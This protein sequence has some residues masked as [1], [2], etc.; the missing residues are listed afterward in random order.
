MTQTDRDVQRK[1]K[2]PRRLDDLSGL[3]VSLREDVL[4]KT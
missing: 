4:A 2:M 1:L 3:G